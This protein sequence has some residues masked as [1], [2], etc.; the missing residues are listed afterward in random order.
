MLVL[1][2]LRLS[3]E[4]A[5]FIFVPAHETASKG[6]TLSA[7]KMPPDVFIPDSNPAL[8]V[9]A[10]PTSVCRRRASRVG[11]QTRRRT[12]LRPCRGDLC[13]SH[14]RGHGKDVKVHPWRSSRL[15]AVLSVGPCV[16]S[17]SLV[18]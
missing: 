7:Q 15:L 6:C 4:F 1:V 14:A 12:P 2:R 9:R 13:R 8:V 10:S 11:C 17:V 5:V 18:F 3:T 16:L